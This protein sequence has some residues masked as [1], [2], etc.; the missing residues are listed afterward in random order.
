MRSASATDEPPYF[1]T[2]REGMRGW[3][4]RRVP[5]VVAAG[6]GRGCGMVTGRA[7]AV[8]RSPRTRRPRAAGDRRAVSRPGIARSAAAPT[9]RSA[10]TASAPPGEPRRGRP[11]QGRRV[12]VGDPVVRERD[13]R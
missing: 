9:A 1:W 11:A 4:A 3:Y 10:A 8:E 13:D 7:A 12:A 6:R 5:P 2:T